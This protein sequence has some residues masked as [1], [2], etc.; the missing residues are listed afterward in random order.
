MHRRSPQLPVHLTSASRHSSELENREEMWL[1]Q[2]CILETVLGLSYHTKIRWA[3]AQR[4]SSWH[5]PKSHQ[6]WAIW[7]IMRQHS[8]L[9]PSLIYLIC[10]DMTAAFL[11]GPS[12]LQMNCSM[13]RCTSMALNPGTVLSG[14]P[15]NL[16]FPGS[17]HLQIHQH[18]VTHH[19]SLLLPS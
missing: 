12:Q 1:H 10:K 3:F 16:I 2:H 9:H 17:C 15:R 6:L 8:S 13:L 18:V 4:S 7:T 11:A 19:Y 5:C 14:T